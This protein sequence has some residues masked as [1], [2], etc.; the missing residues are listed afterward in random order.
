[1]SKLEFGVKQ[2]DYN[3]RNRNFMYRVFS[4]MFL[5]NGRQIT[6]I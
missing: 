4:N 2:N 1:M 6:K 3:N 5:G